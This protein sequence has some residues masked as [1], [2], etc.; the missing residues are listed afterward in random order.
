M[1]PG[2]ISGRVILRK[3]VNGVRA[4]VLGRLLEAAVEAD[5]P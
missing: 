5:Q 1:M 3:V 2:Q 4:E